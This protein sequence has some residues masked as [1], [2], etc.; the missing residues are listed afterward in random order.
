M[1]RRVTL[2][3]IVGTQIVYAVML[4]TYY[5]MWA[6]LDWKPWYTTVQTVLGGIFFVTLFFHAA[7]IRK[8]KKECV[9]ELAERNLRRCDSFCLKLFLAAMIIVAWFCAVAGHGFEIRT[10]MIGWMIVLSVLAL[11]VIRTVMFAVL[12][13][14]G[15]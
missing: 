13:S 3:E 2:K 11:S 1:K 8:Y 10:G 14:K 4:A 6:R 12:D 9:D 15:V 7:R 5:W